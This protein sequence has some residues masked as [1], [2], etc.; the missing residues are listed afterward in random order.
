LFGPELVFVAELDADLL[1]VEEFQELA[2]V[3][4]VGAGGVAEG[5]A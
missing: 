2:L 3:G 4:E 1:G 5:V